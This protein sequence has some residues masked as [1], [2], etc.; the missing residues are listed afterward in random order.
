MEYLTAAFVG[1]GIGFIGF[2]I[3]LNIHHFWLRRPAIAA[4]MAPDA[5]ERRFR[6]A[7][8]MMSED[9]R[10]SIIHSYIDK[11]GCDRVIAMRYA[12]EDYEADNRR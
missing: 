3:W 10:Q 9:R 11:H 1:A 2:W 8:A 4:T 7:F 12:V 5:W 6:N